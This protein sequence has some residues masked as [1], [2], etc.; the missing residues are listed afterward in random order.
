MRA[1]LG[2]VGR[3]IHRY[4]RHRSLPGLV[5]NVGGHYADL[6]Q[7]RRAHRSPCGGGIPVCSG[8]DDQN[9]HRC[10]GRDGSGHCHGHA[11]DETTGMLLNVVQTTQRTTSSVSRVADSV[12]ALPCGGTSSE[13]DRD[14]LDCD[15]GRAHH[16]YVLALG[17]RFEHGSQ[18]E[19]PSVWEGPR[20][21]SY[22]QSPP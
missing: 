9:R 1:A 8:H 16:E 15:H 12:R 22:G 5:A 2:L 13:V 21:V 6:A 4:C 19:Q 17:S 7:R 18:S 14:R 3:E 20:Q 11:D 10:D